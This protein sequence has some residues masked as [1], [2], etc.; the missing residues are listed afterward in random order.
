MKNNYSTT[1]TDH[2]R[3]VLTE[4]LAAFRGFAQ[5]RLGDRELAADVVQDALLKAFRAADNLRDDENLVAW[6]YR[7]LRNAI[8]DLY[9]KK[10]TQAKALERFALELERE[11]GAEAESVVCGCLR[12]LLPTLRT[13]YADVLNRVDLDGQPTGAVAASLGITPGNLKVRLHRSRQQ[14][15]KRLLETCQLGATRGC[16]DCNCEPAGEV[17][18]ARHRARSSVPVVQK[19]RNS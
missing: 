10:A 9:R 7:I 15:K 1:R 13:E 19:R 14:L 2:L 6:F 8:T 12:R 3:E 18:P 11:P 17:P 5:S 4:N 16:A